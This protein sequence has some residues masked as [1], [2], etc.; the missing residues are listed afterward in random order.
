MHRESK[1]EID[2]ARICGIIDK[3]RNSLK[4]VQGI[5][6]KLRSIVSTLVEISNDVNQLETNIRESLR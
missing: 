3:I 5:K 1:K 4:T 6:T 2:T